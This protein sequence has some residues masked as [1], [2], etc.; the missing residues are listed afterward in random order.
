MGWVGT[1][2][3]WYETLDMI[4]DEL[5]PEVIVPGHGPICGVEGA[6]EMKQYLQNRERILTGRSQQARPHAR[7]TWDRMPIGYVL[8]GFI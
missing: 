7:S 3:K 2:D 5:K 1:F 8:N 6:M 4:V